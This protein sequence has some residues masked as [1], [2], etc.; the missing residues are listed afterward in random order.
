MAYK[1]RPYITNSGGLIPNPAVEYIV[2]EKELRITKW[3]N[4]TQ[5]IALPA[6]S[7]TPEQGFLKS[8]FGLANVIIR[9]VGGTEYRC[10]NIRS[11][12]DFI[13][14]LKGTHPDVRPP[15]P[16]WNSDLNDS[17]LEDFEVIIPHVP[18]EIFNALYDTRTMKKDS[19]FEWLEK[20]G[21]GSCSN[22]HQLK[23][24]VSRGFWV[25]KGEPLAYLCSRLSVVA[26]FSGKITLIGSGAGPHNGT[27]L[28]D[29][30]GNITI[31]HHSDNDYVSCQ[32]RIRPLKGEDTKNATS[33]TYAP[34]IKVANEILSRNHT[35]IHCTQE[36]IQHGIDLLKAHEADIKSNSAPEAKPS[37]TEPS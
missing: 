8:Q 10:E 19:F 18:I 1:T 3:F 23:D 28:S 13:S 30:I 36:S 26:P 4:G 7:I 21:Q 17:D 12:K 14:A 34:A 6:A 24:R 20:D 35:F 37:G 15:A 5:H 16:P 2:N 22:Y 25:K 29:S 32:F 9:D 27:W 33:N 11:A 31:E